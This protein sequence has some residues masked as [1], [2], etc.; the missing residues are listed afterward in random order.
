MTTRFQNS[1][2]AAAVPSGGAPE[3]PF[4]CACG[5]AALVAD[6]TNS[7]ARDSGGYLLHP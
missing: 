4:R 2:V 6:A 1:E 5:Y 3:A 7:A